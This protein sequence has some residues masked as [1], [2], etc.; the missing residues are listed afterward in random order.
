ML[1][2]AGID[3]LPDTQVPWSVYEAQLNT[4]LVQRNGLSRALARVASAMDDL[5][6]MQERNQARSR[7]HL[8]VA[9]NPCELARQSCDFLSAI[10]AI[11]CALS[12][13]DPALIPVCAVLLFEAGVM[14]AIAYACGF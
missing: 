7:A 6:T 5:A 4:L 8:L 12:A 9:Q 1:T 3:H 11:I 14:C 10:A 2:E 13:I